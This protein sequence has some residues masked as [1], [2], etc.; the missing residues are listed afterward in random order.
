LVVYCKKQFVWTIDPDADLLITNLGA[1]KNAL[2]AM[3]YENAG[4]EQAAEIHWTRAAKILNEETRDYDGD[5][6][7]TMQVQSFGWAGGEIWNL[8]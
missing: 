5:Y 3:K 6:S 7:A 4:S 8:H 1:L 2:Q